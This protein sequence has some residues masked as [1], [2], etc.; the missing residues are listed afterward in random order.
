MDKRN[1]HT[2]AHAPKRAV[3]R[4]AIAV[5]ARQQPLRAQ[6]EGDAAELVAVRWV[7]GLVDVLNMWICGYIPDGLIDGLM[8]LCSMCGYVDTSL[9]LLLLPKINPPTGRPPPGKTARV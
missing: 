3:E 6:H 8:R 7:D 2:R 1:T 5:A 4:N 9:P